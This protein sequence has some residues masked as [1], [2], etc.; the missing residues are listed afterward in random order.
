[1][2]KFLV[3]AAHADDEVLGVGGTIARRVRE[4]NEVQ[5]VIVGDCRTA[6]DP[7]LSPRL[8][9]EAKASAKVLGVREPLFLFR[10]AMTLNP[11]ID[12]ELNKRISD[13]VST[14]S[15]D[16]VLTHHLTD[17][18]SDHRAVAAAVM[19]ACRPIGQWPTVMSFETPSS[20]EWGGPFLPNTFIELCDEDLEK[21]IEAI[22]CYSSELRKPPHPRSVDSLFT[23]AIYW[24]QLA[25]VQF[26]E[27]FILH[28]EVSRC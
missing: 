23:R 3:V 18:N 12:L 6:R 2:K 1:M 5:V 20:S 17:I 10:K 15:P 22:R 4:G 28:R 9:A 21:K 11:G 24:G 14:A 8:S 7:D 25:G 13:I 26:A 16:I 19:V 27:P